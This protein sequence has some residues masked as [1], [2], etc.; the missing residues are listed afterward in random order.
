MTCK[1]VPSFLSATERRF[2]QLFDEIY[3]LYPETLLAGTL[4]YESAN[5]PHLVKYNGAQRGA[6]LHVDTA[7]KSLTV[8]VLLSDPGDFGGGGT[9][10][11]VLDATVMLKQGE[12]LVHPGEL[13]HAG[14]DIT[15][16][17]RNLLVA[18]FE[19][20]W[21]EVPDGLHITE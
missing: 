7:H 9:Y 3:S 20:E 13:E 14:A 18:F 5:E 16:G 1:S 10:L 19:C 12:V 2:Q 15:F 21:R 17:V 6:P 4:R 11:G 8:N